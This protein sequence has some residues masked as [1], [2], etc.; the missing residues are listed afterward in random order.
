VRRRTWTFLFL[1]TLL[2][3]LLT[4]CGPGEPTRTGAGENAQ[5]AFV[6]DGDTVELA[7]GRRVR[8]IGVDTP[9]TDQPYAAEAE[10]FNQSLVAGQ[11]A[12][13]E[14]DVQVS[15]PYGRLLAYVWVGDTFVN[16]EL[17][18]QGYAHV[19]TVPPS[20]RYADAFVRAEREAREAGR[21]LWALADVSV[22]ITALQYD[23]P[24]RD[25]LAPNGEWIELANQGDGPVDLSGYTLRDE[26][27]HLYTFGAVVLSPGATVRI[28]SGRGSDTAAELYWGLAGDAV[29][30]ND[31]DAAYLR[32][33]AGAFVDSYTYTP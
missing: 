8:Y 1:I 27:P 19:Y 6:V 30:N 22:R 11:E 16:L 26:G 31:G 3:P 17:V 4:S 14:T 2:I 24:G 15:D 9:E 12:W 33:P 28:H 13:L 10:A 21:G 32:D 23:A 25:D 29:W 20:V 5:V 18:R 7:D